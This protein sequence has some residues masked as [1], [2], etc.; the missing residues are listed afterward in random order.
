MGT[1]DSVT[2]LV[3]THPQFLRHD[4]GPHH[5][6]RPARLEAVLAGIAAAHLEDAVVQVSPQPAS[7]VPRP[8]TA[9]A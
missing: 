1:F 9:T 3:E 2:V 5:P 6:E 8:T 4:T 7:R